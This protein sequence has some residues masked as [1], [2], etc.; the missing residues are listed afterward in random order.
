MGKNVSPRQHDPDHVGPVAHNQVCDC[1]NYSEIGS[2]RAYDEDDR[3]AIVTKQRCG[4]GVE[5]IR[6]WGNRL[7]ER[8]RRNTD[9]TRVAK[10]HLA[11]P[12]LA[13]ES[14]NGMRR[15]R[16]LAMRRH[17]SDHVNKC[18]FDVAPRVKQHTCLPIKTADANFKGGPTR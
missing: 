1:R 12:A 10:D 7:D 16:F 15:H 13:G 17:P 11:K 6:P 18:F 14:V 3:L 4:A 9:K 8:G 2:N 5:E